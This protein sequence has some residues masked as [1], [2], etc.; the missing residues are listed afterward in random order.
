MFVD[1]KFT[2]WI[3]TYKVLYFLNDTK[4]FSFQE[5]FIECYPKYK[6][7]KWEET[8]INLSFKKNSIWKVLIQAEI[9]M[10]SN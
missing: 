4:T 5:I 9:P 1:S 6:R 8:S 2:H 7:P 3:P 10:R